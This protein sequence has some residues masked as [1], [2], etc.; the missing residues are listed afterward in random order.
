MIGLLKASWTDVAA[1]TSSW[2]PIAPRLANR[3]R[4]CVAGLC[5]RV[6]ERI[7]EGVR[8]VTEAARDARHR[9]KTGRPRGM[10]ASFVHPPLECTKACSQA[11]RR[12]HGLLYGYS[13]AYAEVR[14]RAGTIAAA[15]GYGKSTVYN[16]FAELR[17]AEL[18]VVH[19]RRGRDG[20]R[21]ANRYQVISDAVRAVPAR[22]VRPSEVQ[23]PSS[24]AQKTRTVIGNSGKSK[25]KPTTAG[26]PHPAAAERR[27]VDAARRGST[28]KIALSEEALGLAVGDERVDKLR[29]LFGDDLKSF[30]LVMGEHGAAQHP[31]RLSAACDALIKHHD[32]I[33]KPARYL[34][35]ILRKQ[36]EEVE[37]LRQE[38]Q[39][40]EERRRQAVSFGDGN[41]QEIEAR[42]AALQS[43]IG[44]AGRSRSQKRSNRVPSTEPARKPAAVPPPVGLPPSDR[45]Q[46]VPCPRGGAPEAL[47][48]LRSSSPVVANILTQ[49]LGVLG[50]DGPPRSRTRVA[51]S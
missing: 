22:G 41:Q 12:V 4:P 16:A 5:D 35:G 9:L 27:T 30:R 32:T 29:A 7:E 37:G 49:E 50:M 13:L 46:P 20:R 45:T 51:S 23:K 19:E 25:L 33:D 17:G 3:V 38:L 44:D 36:Q 6:G 11:A 39:E 26:I 28:E 18:L 48:R 47:Q 15:L 43:T 40:L 14:P 2:C 1:K 31:D 42:V 21:V 8:R 24:E 10:P 34:R